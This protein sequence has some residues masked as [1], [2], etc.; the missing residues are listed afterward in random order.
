MQ[1]EAWEDKENV[2]EADMRKSD[3]RKSLRNRM[4][5]KFFQ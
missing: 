4:S 2:K 5:V 1:K 3:K